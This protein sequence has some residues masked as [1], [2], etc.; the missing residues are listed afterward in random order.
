MRNRPRVFLSHSK[1]DTAFIS[2]VCDDL[3]QCQIDPW[4]DSVDIRHGEPWLDA[5]FEGGI[6]TCDCII[7]YLTE[8]SINSTMVKKEIDASVIQKLKDVKVGLLPYVSKGSLRAILRPDIQSL[9]IPEWNS[10]NYSTLL[11]RIISEIWHVYFERAIITATSDEKVKRLE[12]ELELNRLRE[13]QHGGIFTD[14]EE[15]DFQY[16][17]SKLNDRRSV[18]YTKKTML[19]DTGKETKLEMYYSVGTVSLVQAIFESGYNLYEEYVSRFLLKDALKALLSK[20]EV[21]DIYCSKYPEIGNDL[22]MYGFMQNVTFTKNVRDHRGF[23]FGKADGYETKVETRY[24]FTPKVHR[25]RYW[26]AV[27]GLGQNGIDL[28]PND[29]SDH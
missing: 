16:I 4:L 18:I 14:S 10:E 12:A 9:Q 20:E 15:R 1:A 2:K 26:L 23:L 8:D 11:P 21:Q 28:L 24:E 6:S 22:L 19:G 27:Q 25:F 29:K 13:S 3:R 17:Y 5:I 7:V